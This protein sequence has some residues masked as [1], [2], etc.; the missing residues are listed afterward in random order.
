MSDLGISTTSDV[1]KCKE[2][3]VLANQNNTMNKTTDE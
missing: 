1:T 2:C 3:G